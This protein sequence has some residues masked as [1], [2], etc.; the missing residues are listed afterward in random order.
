MIDIIAGALLISG[1]TLALTAAIGIVRFPDVLT[2]MHAATKPQTLGILLI[3]A[4]VA[5][6]LR[7]PSSVAFIVVIALFQLLTAPVSAHMVGRATF[8]AGV[9]RR[10][11]LT[12]C[13]YDEESR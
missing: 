4:A 11:R 9:V 13:E 7:D 6:R 3:L 8:R 2:R 10:D 5:L 12:I 1:S